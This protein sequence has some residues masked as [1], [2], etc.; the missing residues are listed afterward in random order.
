MATDP[1]AQTL[2]STT[3]AVGRS[4]MGVRDML[5]GG[6]YNPDQW[7]ESVWADDLRLMDDARCN[8]ATVG[9]FAWARLEPADGRFDF[10]WLDRCLDGLAKSGKHVIL[11]T[12]TAAHPA[13]LSQ[14]HPEV[15]RMH[16]D[17]RPPLHGVRVNYCPTAPAFR[18]RAARI[19]GALA[20]RYGRRPELVLWHVH[21][22][23]VRYCYCG[24]C[25]EA[26]RGWLRQRHGTLDALNSAWT[27]SFWSHT[28]SDWAQIDPPGEWVPSGGYGEYTDNSMNL[29][30]RRFQSD[31]QADCMALEI[32]AIR[33]HSAAPV[34]TN[35]MG[36]YVDLDVA[37]FAKHLDVISWD[38]Y[39]L[40]DQH[41]DLRTAISIAF[42]H[43]LMRS[44]KRDQPFLLMETTPSTVNWIATQRLK[45]PGVLRMAGLQAVAHGSDSVL[46][47]QWRR[48]RGGAEKYHG[49]VVG[50]D[51]RNDAR[52]FREV[53][54]VGD[55]L[56]KLAPVVGSV[57]RSE[58]AVIYD[59]ENRWAIDGDVTPAGKRDYEE[60]CKEHYGWFWRQGIATDVIDMDV[61]LDRYR[62]VVA[63]MLFLL[64]PHT[65]KRLDEFVSRGGTLVMTYWSGLVDETDRCFL[66]DRP[67]AATLGIRVEETDATFDDEPNSLVPKPGTPGLS[68][69]YAARQLLDIVHLEGAEALATYGRDF[70]AGTPALT[71]NR[72][73]AGQAFYIT[74][75]NDERFHRDFYGWLA[76]DL[77]LSR[78][79]P[80]ELPEGVSACV[81]HGD[82]VD[83]VFVLNTTAALA[84]VDA[85]EGIELES[86][87]PAQR[88]LRLPPYAVTVIS[89]AVGTARPA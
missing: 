14:L 12:P 47:F 56:R 29:D 16:R 32:A 52:V 10:A 48:S 61:D 39:P 59:W 73:G 26:F 51:G 44:L 31:Q 11:A 23:Y 37:R 18:M 54:M 1:I 55:S 62:V 41:Y 77:G 8:T 20:E 63:P 85:G 15:V 27:T 50:H 24:L 5:H 6:D 22:E 72:R 57:V 80:G 64:K 78:A 53:A 74:S 89:R 35:L 19:A 4:P 65:A 40:Y 88:P 9:V 2:R 79:V 33:P 81:R 34:T 58:V 43:D 38:G 45:R 69:E 70:Y 7:P 84:T 83:F 3:G 82:G 30:W 67:L 17:R 60:T 49:A 36:T 75:R 42:Q 87:Q 86:G 25:A 28:Y 71:R 76:R 66:G 21:N 13:W 68:G 46:Y